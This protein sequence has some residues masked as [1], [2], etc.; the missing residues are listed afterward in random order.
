[1]SYTVAQRTNE[2]GIRL[3]LG[4]QRGDIIRQVLWEA[5]L[6]VFG[7]VALGMGV[8]LGV[9]RF[10]A[11]QLFG[12]TATDPVTILLAALVMITVAALAGYL[13]ARRAARV[14]PMIALRCE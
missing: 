11:S 1:M 6:P 10:V 9:T 12:L 13:P 8:A 2:M 14:D 4:A 7:G 3:A 5:M